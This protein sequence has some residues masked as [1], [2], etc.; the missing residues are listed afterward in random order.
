VGTNVGV[1][2]ATDGGVA[3]EQWTTL[4]GSLP[5]VPVM[6][7]SMSK[8]RVLS[9]ATWGRGVW[10]VDLSSLVGQVSHYYDAKCGST[11]VY[12]GHL[13]QCIS[14]AQ[15]VDGETTGCG[16]PGVYCNTIPPDYPYWGPQAW[17]QL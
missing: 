17:Q 15:G 1:D 16:S 8:T 9:A 2:V 4:A 6:N 5:D 12:N 10:T 11:V 3:G 14:Q 13:W 7:L